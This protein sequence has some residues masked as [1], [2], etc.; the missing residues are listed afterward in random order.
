MHSHCNVIINTIETP[1]LTQS[2]QYIFFKQYNCVVIINVKM[3][4]RPIDIIIIIESIGF[5][6]TYDLLLL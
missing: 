3:N 6:Q 5:K 1:T 4:I 2:N